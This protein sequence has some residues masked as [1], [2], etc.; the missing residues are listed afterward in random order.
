MK[1]LITGGAGFL[2][3]L[4]ARTLLERGQL[5]GKPLGELVVAD[6]VRVADD[7]AGRVRLLQGPLAEQGARIAA[8]RFDVVFHLAGAVSSEC[9]ADFDLGLAANLDSTRAVL[10]AL[11]SAGNGARLVFS[12]SVAVFGVD[13]GFRL[14]PVIT[15]FTLP[16]PQSSYGIQKFVSE[17]L[18][19]DYTRKGFID[20]RSG[21]LMTVAVRPGKPNKA[22][23]SFLSGVVREPVNGQ[24]AVCPVPLEME[25]ALASPERT[26][27]GLLA[28]AE[29]DGDAL[30]GRTAINFPALT[31]TVGGILEALAAEAGTEARA[32]V[33]LEPDA[34]I[35]RIVGGWP[36]RVESERAHRLGLRPDPDMNAIVRQFLAGRTRDL[37]GIVHSAEV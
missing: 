24:A 37:A 23:S 14:P 33:R 12:S 30:G 16:V 6:R 25:V 21:R 4:L 29:A 13:A 10:E 2:G 15:D 8:E 20:G 32:R 9:E 5:L 3:S 31:V 19:A 11:R 36:S 34:A 7:L 35:E 26:I 1:V 17:Q 18:V 27:A 28:L 22:A